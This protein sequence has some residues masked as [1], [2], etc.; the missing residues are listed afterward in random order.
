[1]K[2]IITLMK[3]G[4]A[5]LNN[6][7]I[8]RKSF[9]T[10]LL[11]FAVSL[12]F[13][14]CD[15]NAIPEVT[16]NVPDGGTYGKFFFHVQ[17]APEVNFYFD[18]KKVSSV[19]SS[20]SDEVKGNAYGSVFPSNAYALISSG[21]FNVSVRDLE[22]NT[23][24]ATSLTFAA[25]SHYSVYLGGTEENYEIFT[26]EDDLPEANYEKIYW[27]FV[28]SMANMPFAVDAY[29]V[30]AA[31][32]ATENTP[33]EPVEIVTLG[34]G[35]AFKQ[36]GDYK[37]L[38]PGKYNYRIF[39]SGTDYDVE[40]STPYIQNTITLGSLGRVYSTQIRGTYAPTP[41]SKNIDYWRE[42]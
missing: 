25:D 20:T 23:V 13:N 15:E 21:T 30:R 10:I 41:S 36:A 42:R 1:M 9:N 17:N 19:A 35:I 6:Y 14:A 29:A 31:V 4:L 3:L 16:E 32:P 22:G 39:E 40:T 34:T 5:N 38:K 8:M 33:A 26:I 18:E 2:K 11:L 28:N 12:V 7:K 37:E 24:A 27:R